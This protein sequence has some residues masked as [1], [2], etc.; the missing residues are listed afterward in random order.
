[1]S[2]HAYDEDELVVLLAEALR[3]ERATPQSVREAGYA[4]YAWR[5][6]DIELAALTYDSTTDDLALVGSRSEQAPL[7]ALTFEGGSGF[8]IELE[9]APDA[10]L[11][12]LVPAQSGEVRV[13][14]RDGTTTSV[15]VTELG[16][17]T[18]TPIPTG[19]FRLQVDGD[20]SVA[21]D[22]FTL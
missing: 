22:W 5:T 16:C 3:A 7:R 18:I 12:Q 21:T 17:F 10:I 8:S 19:A 14:L 15:P 13:T 6:I 4:A 2:E 20:R 9:I 11:G 1:M